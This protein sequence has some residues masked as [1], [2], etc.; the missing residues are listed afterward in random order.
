MLGWFTS[1]L[2]HPRFFCHKKHLRNFQSGWELA[3]KSESPWAWHLQLAF[4]LTLPWPFGFC[5][6]SGF[7]THI[8]FFPR[9]LCLLLVACVLVVP[10]CFVQPWSTS[11]IGLSNPRA[12]SFSLSCLVSVPLFS[13]TLGSHVLLNPWQLPCPAT[14]LLPSLESSLWH[15]AGSL[16]PGS[17]PKIFLPVFLKLLTFVKL[18]IGHV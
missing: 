12:Y 13:L 18:H 16:D 2:P 14:N 10:D 9:C 4:L 1:W 11:L 3:S 7:W 17:L 15:I 6:F 8:W 5:R